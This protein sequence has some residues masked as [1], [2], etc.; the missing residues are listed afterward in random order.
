MIWQ[1]PHKNSGIVI[2]D[3][4]FSLNIKYFQMTTLRGCTPSKDVSMAFGE[5]KCLL[6]Y[7]RGHLRWFLL[8][9]V[10]VAR[11]V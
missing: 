4:S 2:Q 8:P 7:Q 9:R 5:G 10:T 1:A 6:L 11:P 3:A